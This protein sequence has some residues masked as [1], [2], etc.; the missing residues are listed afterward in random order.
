MYTYLPVFAKILAESLL[1]L[2]PIFVKYINISFNLQMWSRFFTYTVISIFFINW[3]FIMDNIL[4]KNGILLSLI[5]IVHVYSSYRGFELLESGVSYILF[6]TYPLLIQ[7]FSGI[8]IN[9]KLLISI[10]MAILGVYLLSRTDDKK[11]DYDNVNDVNDVSNK[12][13]F[14]KKDF[15]ENYRYEGIIMIMIAAITE[16]L[17]YF[18]VRNLKSDNSWNY[19]FLS[20]ALGTILM[21]V[22][23]NKD[24]RNIIE[25]SSKKDEQ[26][27]NKSSSSYVLI[28][29]L[30]INSIIGLFGY[31]LRF[32]AIKKLDTKVYS[33][34]SYFGILMA[35]V[36]GVIFNKD[37]IT[38]QKIIGTMLI[39]IP[40]IYV[41]I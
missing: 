31:L 7:L 20:Y 41:L 1:S 37:V 4:S 2:Y 21:T 10:L 28:I 19:V 26:F 3:K 9:T 15:K 34:L 24:I 27:K 5:S 17:I 40:N 13:V 14:V 8:K 12:S 6:Y 32:Y 22:Y 16:A 38:V 33:M 29:S 23:Y 25:Q 11:E 39:L 35:Y 18:L 36:Y 30:I